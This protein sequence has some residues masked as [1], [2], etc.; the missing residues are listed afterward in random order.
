MQAGGDRVARRLA[1]GDEQ[2]EEEQIE[3]DLTEAVLTSRE[4]VIN[5]VCL[6]GGLEITIPDGMTV[7]NEAVGI[8]GG[9][10]V[11]GDAAPSADA[12]VLVIKGAAIFGGIEVRR[13]K[14]RKGRGR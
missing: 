5:S 3:L 7:R 8:F 4:T 9:V 1:A 10:E 12:P 11:R 6:F 2:Y 14:D 13:A